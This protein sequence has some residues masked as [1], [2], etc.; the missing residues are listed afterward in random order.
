[1]TTAPPP[2]LS[3]RRQGNYA[4]AVSRLVAFALDIGISWGLFTL[5]AAV[6][7]YAIRLLSGKTVSLNN[8]K[9]VSLAVLVVWEFVYFFYQWGLAGRTIGMATLGVQVVKADGSQIGWGSAFWRTLTFPLSFLF[10]GL[11][12]LGII[13]NRQRQAWHDR[14]AKTAVVY[15]W[16]ARAARLRWLA[17]STPA[18][19]GPATTAAGAR[20]A[21]A[22]RP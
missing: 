6:V 16:D 7:T 19:S 22:R 3:D 11:G 8:F 4:G 15:S 12:F 9:W 21:S 1:M 14:F 10:F 5:G 17:K 13:V 20:P 2:D 18:T